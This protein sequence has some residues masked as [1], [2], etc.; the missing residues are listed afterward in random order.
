MT[1]HN[2]VGPQEMANLMNSQSSLV[3]IICPFLSTC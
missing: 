1:N 2:M 3:S